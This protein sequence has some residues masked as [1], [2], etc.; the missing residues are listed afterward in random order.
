MIDHLA[1]VKQGFTSLSGSPRELWKAYVLKF[2]DSYAYFSFSIIFTLFLSREFGYTDI[3]AGTLYGAWGALITIYGVLAGWIVDNL[4]VAHSLR[5]GFFLSL[6]SRLLIFWTTSRAVI[7]M[8]ICFLLPFANCLGIPVLS[9]GI[10]RYT[11][12]ANRSFALGLFYV[13]VSFLEHVFCC[14]IMFYS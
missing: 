13:S 5:V 14:C 3:Q 10:R 7:L 4:G 8:N 2:L 6:L 12:K 9:T 11:S 1:K